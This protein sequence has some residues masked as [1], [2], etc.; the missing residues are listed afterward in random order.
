MLTEAPLTGAPE[1]VET[2]T[3]TV[4]GALGA[5]GSGSTSTVAMRRS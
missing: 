5:T 3:T 2:L 4:A 1:I